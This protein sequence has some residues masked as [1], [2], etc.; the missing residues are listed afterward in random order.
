MI[1]L[2]FSMIF[3]CIARGTFFSKNFSVGNTACGI[4]VVGVFVQF[5][6]LCRL[7][8]YR[9][10]WKLLGEWFMMDG[11]RGF[12]SIMTVIVAGMSVV[13]RDKDL[14]LKVGL[15]RI[16]FELC[17]YLIILIC[18]LSFT[19]RS[20]MEFYFFFEASLVPT[21]W[22]ILGWGYQPERLQAGVFILMYTVCGS[23]PLLMVLLWYYLELGRDCFCISI[24]VFNR[25]RILETGLVR[26]RWVLLILGFFIKL[27]VYFFHGWLPKAHVE[28]PLSGSIILAGILLKL[29]GYGVIR[30]LSVFGRTLWVTN[31]IIVSVAVIGGFICRILCL[32][33]RDV[34]A[35]IAYS[36]IGHMGMRLGGILSSLKRG[37]DGGI[38]IIFSHGLCSPCLFCLAAVSYSVCNSRSVMIRKGFLVIFPFLRI[39]WFVFS[40]LNIGCPPSVNFLSEVILV[41]RILRISKFFI[42]VLG[43]LRFVGGVYCINLYTIVNHGLSRMF[44][45]S[46]RMVG[47][48]HIVII[49]LCIFVLFLGGLVFD[50]VW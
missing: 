33:Q 19:L 28:A 5:F 3:L 16:G 39:F 45:V 7:F 22:L 12:M 23:F 11:L 41:A 44:L 30:M 20:W 29:G 15:F 1:L 34:K 2:L 18:V 38:W 10:C 21:F 27:P 8:F 14:S 17:I 50:L 47:E 43:I 37:V 26:I 46:K 32:V 31:I 25:Q 36:S 24:L 42:F 48:R 4:I 40:R 49:V 13:C 9:Q 35:L 6:R